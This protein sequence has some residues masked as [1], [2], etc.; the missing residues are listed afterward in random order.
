MTTEWTWEPDD[1]AA[2]W[3]SAA[4]DRFPRPLHFR[5]RFTNAEAFHTH[6]I[7][8]RERNN[9]EEMEKIE[10]AV[11]TL[12]TSDIRIEILGGTTRHSDS[13]N[14]MKEYRIVGARNLHHA[15][16]LRQTATDG[17]DGPIRL[18]LCRTETLAA[19]IVRLIPPCPPGAD[20]PA[21]FHCRDVDQRDDNYFED[22][23]HN[24]PRE[25]YQRLVGRPADGGGS[26]GLLVGSILGR[27]PALTTIRWYDIT[28]DGRYTEQR[29]VE[30]IT[31]RPSTP[32]ALSSLFTAWIDKAAQRLQEDA[33]D[34]W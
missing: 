16:V 24:A 14:R 33:A 7:S 20:A 4:V 11:H 26:A 10:L 21:T 15:V 28:D 5:S 12:T 3:F 2:F 23:A 13:H 32:A 22:V 31:V 25:Q 1:F 6:R 19:G 8:V 18:S 17:E 30:H 9:A 34:A 29:T 27:P